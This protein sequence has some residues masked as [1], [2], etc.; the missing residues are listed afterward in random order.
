MTIYHIVPIINPSL[1]YS[2]REIAEAQVQELI[3]DLV[4]NGNDICAW[5]T[6]VCQV[7]GFTIEE[8]WLADG[9]DQIT[10]VRLQG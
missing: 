8:H 4:K 7:E 2:T 9:E 3:A 10:A 5:E 6:V 1:A